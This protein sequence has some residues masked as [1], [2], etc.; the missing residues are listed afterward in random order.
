MSLNT[1][2]GDASADS[3]AT[4]AEFV[5]YAGS[6]LPVLAW[7][8]AA[9]DPTR[10]AALR[11]ACRELDQDFVWTG[12]AV[13]STQAL[14]WPRSG[15]VNRNGFA[16]ATSAIP[17]SLKDAQCEFALQLG[18][19]DRLGDNDPLKKGIIGLKAGSVELRFSDAQAARGTTYDAADIDIRRKQSDLQYVQDVVPDEVRRLLVASWYEQN[20]V[21]LP[22]V[23]EAN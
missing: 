4:L 15:M 7:F 5:D 22:I 1:T 23:F 6:R 21:K 18:A 20:S 11:A 19:S 14:C 10:E 12:S 9:D 8:T 16:I 3:Y 2:P 17:K 13:D